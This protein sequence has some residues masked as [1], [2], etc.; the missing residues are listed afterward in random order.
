MDD[1]A[2]AVAEAIVEAPVMESL[3]KRFRSD[4]SGG[5]VKRRLRSNAEGI[6]RIGGIDG[7]QLWMY[8]RMEQGI[9]SDEERE[10][11]RRIKNCI[12]HNASRS[13]NKWIKEFD[14]Q[15]EVERQEA[16]LKRLR[17]QELLAARAREQRAEIDPREAIRA[18]LENVLELTPPPIPTPVPTP[19]PKAYSRK[20][21]GECGERIGYKLDCI[22][23]EIQ[24]PQPLE[25]EADWPDDEPIQLD[26]LIAEIRHQSSCESTC[27]AP[28]ETVVDPP[29]TVTITPGGSDEDMGAPSNA[30]GGDGFT[31][32]ETASVWDAF[33]GRP[34]CINP[35][36]EFLEQLDEE[37]R[38]RSAAML[39][40]LGRIREELE[41]MPE[42][43]LMDA[44]VCIQLQ[45][46]LVLMTQ[47][48]ARLR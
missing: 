11:L 14:E 44:P 23:R 47:L 16:E 36:S 37:P 10:E 32:H 48:M 3:E 33:S 19:D 18:R 45:D 26:E 7:L 15:A 6:Y 1:F 39:R 17:T 8:A 41:A 43:S 20:R 22:I 35:S 27:C 28:F 34:E 24:A 25:D 42:Q 13:R 21:K 30:I 4:S 9:G 2:M 46:A 29:V 40:S 5:P 31:N 38:L 12:V